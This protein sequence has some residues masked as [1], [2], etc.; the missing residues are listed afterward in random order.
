MRLLPLE[1]HVGVVE[2][3]SLEIKRPS[4]ELEEIMDLPCRLVGLAEAPSAPVISRY[5]LCRREHD[6]WSGL[7]HV[8]ECARTDAHLKVKGQLP[9]K[10]AVKPFVVRGKLDGVFFI[11]EF[12]RQIEPGSKGA[13]AC[14]RREL[15]EFEVVSEKKGS[16]ENQKSQTRG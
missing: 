2:S 11:R 15:R 3:Q 12:S 4:D 16:Q 14:G 5:E 6:V 10:N 8:F 7:D 1:N 13:S 9:E